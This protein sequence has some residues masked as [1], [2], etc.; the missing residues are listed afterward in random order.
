MLSDCLVIRLLLV[1][2]QN[3][4]LLLVIQIKPLIGILKAIYISTYHIFT[5]HK[6]KLY[7][8]Y[9]FSRYQEDEHS[10]SLKH[11]SQ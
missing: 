4:K 8:Y 3:L 7:V 10:L 1:S 9:M 5:K 11:N 2:Y 6:K